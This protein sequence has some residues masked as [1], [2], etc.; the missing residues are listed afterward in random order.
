METD[1]ILE[2]LKGTS[3]EDKPEVVETTTVEEIKDTTILKVVEVV[4][5]VDF[6]MGLPSYSNVSAFASAKCTVTE[7]DNPA[8]VLKLAYALVRK[9]A[10]AQVALSVNAQKAWNAKLASAN[11]TDDVLEVLKSVGVLVAMGGK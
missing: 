3:F 9:Q 5:S 7:T 8:T 11:L 2:K 10:L 6:K 1:T 4:V